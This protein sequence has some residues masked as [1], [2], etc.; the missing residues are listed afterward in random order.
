VQSENRFRFSD[1]CFEVLRVQQGCAAS[2]LIKVITSAKAVEVFAPNP[3][4]PT[5][6]NVQAFPRTI[7]ILTLRDTV[8]DQRGGT[9]PTLKP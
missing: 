2:I 7:T 8:A 5:V 1:R 6:C 9:F 3:A 4:V